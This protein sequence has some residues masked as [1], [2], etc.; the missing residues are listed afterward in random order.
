MAV[1]NGIDRID[2]DNVLKK[3]G[4][5]IKKIEKRT[6]KGLTLAALHVKGTAQEFTPID[7][8]NLRASAY[9]ISPD[10]KVAFKGGRF[11]SKKSKADTGKLLNDHEVEMISSKAESQRWPE[12]AIIG[13]SAYYAVFVHEIDN[14]YKAPGVSWMYLARALKQ[15]RRMI[16]KIIKDRAK[17]K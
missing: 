2:V 12:S 8:G 17:I 7:E 15:E 5:E 16:L 4:R 3:L 11:E 1:I 10:K 6:D 9:V 14:N 13:Y